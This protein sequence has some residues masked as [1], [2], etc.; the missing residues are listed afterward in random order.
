MVDMETG[1]YGQKF[2][3]FEPRVRR[4]IAAILAPGT[5][6]RAGIPWHSSRAVRFG[7]GAN[8]ALFANLPKE[9]EPSAKSDRLDAGG[10][11]AWTSGTLDK[12]SGEKGREL[13]A[14]NPSENEV[15]LFAR[16]GRSGPYYYM[17]RLGHPT[18]DGVSDRPFRMNWELLD[19]KPAKIDLARIGIEG[20]ESVQVL[21]GFPAEPDPPRPITESP[22]RPQEP[23]IPPPAGEGAV[24]EQ[25]PSHI[26][27]PPLPPVEPPDF[28]SPAT[29]QIAK[30]GE[31]GEEKREIY[32]MLR[33]ETGHPA[34]PARFPLLVRH[35]TP[36]RGPVG[37]SAFAP[38]F[39]EEVK[40]GRLSLEVPPEEGDRA[41][42]A[43][44]QYERGLL[45]KAGRPD[46]AERVNTGKEGEYPV[47]YSFNPTQG[48][49]PFPILVKATSGP[50]TAPFFLSLAELDFL[51][52]AG[53]AAIIYR[54][55][56]WN[57]SAPAADFFV[58]HMPFYAQGALI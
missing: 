18:R 4:D 29:P 58:I 39:I 15:L 32:R 1:T 17:G 42:G 12:F 2:G 24:W 37:D 7:D 8:Y 41:V 6:Y 45:L 11:L 5:A 13:A 36:W 21:A 49:E 25:A 33:R 28:M 22:Y 47:V 30:E 34:P 52:A 53:P 40:N 44:A 31:D 57:P 43:I 55:Y 20:S 48:P 3:P 51:E 26:H 46:L 10:I 9:G 50:D 54:I 27:E 38:Q 23:S 56:G 19:I 14:H 35:E 16:A